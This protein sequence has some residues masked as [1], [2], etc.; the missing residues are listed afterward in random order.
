MTGMYDSF[1]R[2]LTAFGEKY[3]EVQEPKKQLP[4]SGLQH[5]SLNHSGQMRA[6]VPKG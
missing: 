1:R 6:G 3:F 2:L 5:R 4:Q